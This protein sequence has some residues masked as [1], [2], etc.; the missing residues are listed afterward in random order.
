MEIGSGIHRYRWIEH[1][2]RIPEGKGSRENGRTHGVVEVESGNILV[3]HQ[4]DPAVLIFDPSGRLLDRWG[5]RFSGAHGMTLVR[6]GGTEFLWLTDEFSG[7]VTKTTLDGRT[8]DSIDRPEHPAYQRGKYAPTWVAVNETR[9]GGNGDVWVADGY[10]TGLV[11]RYDAKGRY[12]Q[13]ISGE[14]GGGR[15]DCP[16]GIMFDT[17]LGTPELVVADRGNKRLQIYSAEGTY[18][19]TF[20]SDVL[21][22][23][24]TAVFAF[25]HFYVPELTAQVTILDREGSLV[26]RLGDDEQT[27]SVD[28]W[29]NHP[30]H[31]VHEG[32]FVAPHSLTVDRHGNIFVVE[33]KVGGRITKLERLAP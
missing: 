26:C 3:F 13:S 5:N 15:F 17:H 6:E 8:V 20:G 14:E 19:R 31:L 4:A 2:A 24:D 10:G 29:P 1:W 18:L 23:P 7:E 28:G 27:C 9:F 12:L 22:C 16:H 32:K 11:H 25:N 30:G 21:R 33:W